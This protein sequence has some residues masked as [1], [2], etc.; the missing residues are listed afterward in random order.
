MTTR[1]FT[2]A[3]HSLGDGFDEKTEI[4]VYRPNSVRE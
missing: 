2:S 1:L 3:R 4:V